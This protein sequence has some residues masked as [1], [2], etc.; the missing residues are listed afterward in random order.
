MQFHYLSQLD[1]NLQNENRHSSFAKHVGTPRLLK[2][3][4]RQIVYRLANIFD[5]ILHIHFF[6]KT[7]SDLRKS[8]NIPYYECD[9]TR[10]HHN[11]LMILEF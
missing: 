4:Y 8:S 3:A 2:F 5:I 1:L 9:M 10:D 6:H 11:F 7:F